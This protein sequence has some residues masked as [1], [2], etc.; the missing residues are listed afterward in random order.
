MDADVSTRESG[1]SGNNGFSPLP[2]WGNG[3]CFS[4]I[5]YWKTVE[6]TGVD[7]ILIG[8]GALIKPWILYVLTP[9][10]RMNLSI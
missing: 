10:T 2:F 9:T 6:A 7:G 1:R 3:D 8:R 5:E 4:G